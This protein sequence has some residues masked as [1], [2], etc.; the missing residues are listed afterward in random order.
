MLKNSE[1][2]DLKHFDHN[3]VLLNGKNKVCFCVKSFLDKLNV[4]WNHFLYYCNT[5]QLH[6]DVSFLSSTLHKIIQHF[7]FSDNFTALLA[8]FKSIEK[9]NYKTKEYIM[10][11]N[12]F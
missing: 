1:L 11:N 2:I 6:N 10:K 12:I 7:I 8:L 9:E 4:N 5:N 3:G